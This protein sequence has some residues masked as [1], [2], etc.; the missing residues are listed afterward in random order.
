MSSR[1][2]LHHDVIP[3]AGEASPSG[4]PWMYL[5]HGIFGAGRNWRSIGRRV[6]ETRP[7]WGAVAVDLRLH[8]RSPA[9]VPP[10]TLTACAADLE[11][12]ARDT[13][14]VPTAV[15][16]HSFGGKVALSYLK[17]AASSGP[18]PQQLWIM[19]STPAA[20]VPT[21]DPQRMLRTVRALP[22]IFES[23]ARAIDDLEKAGFAHS[24]GQWMSANLRRTEQG[25]VWGLD[26]DALEGLLEDFFRTDLWSVVERPPEGVSLHFVRASRS[27]VL[28]APEA[29]RIRAAGRNEPV[30]LHLV[31]GGHW[32]NADNPS[33]VLDLLRQHLP[34]D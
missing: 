4:R 2:R 17:L 10:H 18:V 27:N 15:L 23:R 13:D 30:F 22:P 32:L 21:G 29:E 16:G 34:D 31:E 19:D 33:A 8:G 25:L 12:L 5:L 9:F 28:T 6:S 26:F 7:P 20:R 1:P 11:D 3:A 14:L 24:V